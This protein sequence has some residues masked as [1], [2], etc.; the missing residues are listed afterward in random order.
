MLK[1]LLFV[2]LG[3]GIGSSFRYLVSLWFSKHSSFIFPW[4]TFVI[5]ITGCF[6][7]G[8]LMDAISHNVVTNN[9][10]KLLLVVG[11]CGGYTTFSTFSAENLRLLENGSYVTLVIY[12]TT[13]VILGLLAVWGGY[14]LSKIIIP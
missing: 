9:N 8:F 3:G 1:Q 2:A 10:L 14:I 11:L 13:S 5:N 12:I 6:L 7:I 4:G